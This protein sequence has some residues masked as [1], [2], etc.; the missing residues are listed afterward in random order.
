MELP[1]ARV[2]RNLPQRVGVP[3]FERLEPHVLALE[4]YVKRQLPPSS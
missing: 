2:L 3:R 4:R 1:G